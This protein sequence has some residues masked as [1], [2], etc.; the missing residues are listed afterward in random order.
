MS[1]EPRRCPACGNVN[2]LLV[3]RGL[4]G[5]TDEHDQYFTC[6]DCGRVTYEIVSRTP[7]DVRIQRM[8]TGRQV[9]IAGDEY[10]VSRVL[11]VGLNE[12]LVYLKPIIV[13]AKP[14]TRLRPSRH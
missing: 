12:S 2:T 14:A 9:R 6:Q 11:K 5:A 1:E 10:S 8:E 4:A 13:P 3:Q 7:K